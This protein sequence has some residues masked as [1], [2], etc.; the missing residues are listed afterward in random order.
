M[1][2][3]IDIRKA[4]IFDYP[5]DIIKKLDIAI[6]SLHSSFT[7]SCEENTSRAVSALE[8]D[9]FDFLA[10]PTGFVFGNRAPIFIDIDRIIETCSKY[11]KALEINSYYM[12]MD[13]NEENARKA[14]DAGVKLAINTD[15]HRPGNMDM[16]DMGVDLARRAGLEAKDIINTS[17]IDELVSWKNGRNK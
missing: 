12:R 10:H 2:A 14:K 8:K 7:N 13:L 1:G 3:E 9:Y 4:G 17:S 5:P 6:A 15:S 11:G 16:I